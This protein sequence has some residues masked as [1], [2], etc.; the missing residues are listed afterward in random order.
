MVKYKSCWMADKSLKESIGAYGKVRT[1]GKSK[2]YY[3]LT[4]SSL[5]VARSLM[6]REVLSHDEALNRLQTVYN[7]FKSILS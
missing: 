1:S 5:K 6:E 4:Q 7:N 3:G 2:V